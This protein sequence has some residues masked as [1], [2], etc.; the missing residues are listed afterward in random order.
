MKMRRPNK[1][2]RFWQELKRRNVVRVITVYAAAAFVILELVDIVAPSL[3]LPLWTLNLVLILLIVGFIIAI[4]LGWVYDIH[5]EGGI[6][7]TDPSE[8]ARTAETPKTSNGW[9]IASY[10]SFAVIIGLIVLNII[11]RTDKTKI[12]E[13]SIAVLPFSYFNANPDA[14]DIG[15][16]FTSEIITQ[17]YKVRGFDR[18][19][20]YTSTL[21]YKGP[22]KPSL[23][24]IG[25]ELGASYII[26]GSLERQNEKV[27]IHVQIIQAA[28]DDHIWAEEFSG[29]WEDIFLIRASIAKQIAAELKTMLSKGEQEQIEEEPTD[30]LDAYDFYLLGNQYRM[31]HS[32][33]NLIKAI[34]FY[35]T[36]AEID[37][38]FALAYV[39]IGESYMNLFWHGNWIPVDAYEPARL[40]LLKA[41]EIN[42]Q[43]AEG[44]LSLGRLYLEYDWDIKAAEEELKNAILLNP[45]LSQ[46]YSAYAELLI[47]TGQYEESHQCQI[48][49]L[50][51]DPNSISNQYYLGYTLYNTGQTDSAIN[52][53]R[54]LVNAETTSLDPS[55][56][57]GYIY[58]ENGDY[59]NAIHELE[60]YVKKD[61]VSQHYR[62]YLGIAYAKAGMKD[63]TRKHLEALK[64][65]EKE[66]RTVSFGKAALHA[67]LGEIDSAIY[68][69]QRS[70]DERYQHL[71]YL[72]PV[73]AMFSTIR[74]DPGF[75]EIY[76]KVWPDK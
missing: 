69:L 60:K 57:L 76:K 46:A 38:D 32:E 1:L 35:E 72:R 28:S 29:N 33:E 41:L 59:L 56:L 12:L 71:L 9:K 39:G 6:V 16:A 7:K 21:R 54:T 19:I 14:E 13:K 26:E 11:P 10:I 31:S 45:N 17:L 62:M 22:A 49:A 37:P 55:Y 58:L 36:A 3:G 47:L 40:A 25:E 8:K 52:Y 51:L 50:K 66:S 65:L 43:L 42:D 70:Y 73:K 24:V 53:L 74:S 20:S 34:H 67:E 48:Q 5:P 64:A 23:P 44:H 18:I 15:D 2:V 68:W 4:I 27:S 30:N 61:S 63:Q 75:I